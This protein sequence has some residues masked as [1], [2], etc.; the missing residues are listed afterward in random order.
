MIFADMGLATPIADLSRSELATGDIIG[1]HIYGAVTI[2]KVPDANGETSMSD[3]VTRTG[4][5]MPTGTGL[6][7]ISVSPPLVPVTGE[8][9]PV[10]PE[11]PAWVYEGPLAPVGMEPAA[12]AA[13]PTPTPAPAVPG[14]PWYKNWK[15]MLGIGGG[16]AALGVGAFILLR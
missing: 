16:V 8:Q 6:K 9:P 1:D 2:G 10:A 4:S 14:T 3:M 7:P 12:A 5:K 11:I 15:I 13:T